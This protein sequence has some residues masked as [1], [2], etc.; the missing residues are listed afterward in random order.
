MFEIDIKTKKSIYEQVIDGI[1]ADI[2]SGEY[3]P[4]AK[5][6]SVRDLS[7]RLTVNPNTIQK[8]YKELEAQGWIFTASGLGCFVSEDERPRD[9][10][11]VA[12]LYEELGKI[13]EQLRFLGESENEIITK[14]GGARQ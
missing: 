8:A 5:L 1:K 9:E 10:R 4:G 11:A 6:P 7:S 3:A 2:M 14:L 13:A 12:A